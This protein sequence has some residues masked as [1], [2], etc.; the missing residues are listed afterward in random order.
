MQVK[1]AV[2]SVKMNSAEIEVQ[3]ASFTSGGTTVSSAD[4]KTNADE[5]T[6]T[7]TFPDNLPLGTGQIH[8][9]FTGILNDKL[10]GF[11]RSC[12]TGWSWLCC[13]IC[14]GIIT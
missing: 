7:V 4:I 9:N 12:Y 8:L 11:Y 10:R 2:N 14:K 6:L 3:S 1:E 5:E 13:C